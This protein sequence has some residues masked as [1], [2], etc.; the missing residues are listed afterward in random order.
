MEP[1]PEETA[2]C[3]LRL[4]RVLTGAS[5]GMVLIAFVLYALYQDEQQLLSGGVYLWAL[6][7]GVLPYVLSLW[8]LMT[9]DE[10]KGTSL[11]LSWAPLALVF[12]VV[13]VIDVLDRFRE[14]E[15]GLLALLIGL[16]FPVAQAA[17]VG[18]VVLAYRRLSPQAG[19][20]SGLGWGI[21]RA[22]GFAVITFLLAGTALPGMHWDVYEPRRRAVFALRRIHACATAYAASH[23]E[24]GFPRGLSALGPKGSGC[25]GPRLASG[26]KDSYRFAYAAGAPDEA[27]RTRSFSVIARPRIAFRAVRFLLDE[28]R[29]IRYTDEIRDPTGSDP[30]IGDTLRH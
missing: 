9:L 7:L 27:G 21:L 13:E 10:R 5:V 28:T 18:T 29:T 16:L 11:L 20:R 12:G 3:Y 19:K 4:V 8:W 1:A 22:A 6:G 15:V 17:L 25:L 14:K 2:E 24:Q 30:A 26:E 23:P